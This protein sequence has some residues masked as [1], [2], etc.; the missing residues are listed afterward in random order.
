VEGFDWFGDDDLLK[1]NFGGKIVDVKRSVFTKPKFG[2]NLF[3]RLFEKGWDAFHVRDKNGRIYVDLKEDWMRPLIDSMKYNET[4][5]APISP[6]DCYLRR[7][8]SI[9]SESSEF[10]FPI[11]NISIIGPV[12]LDNGVNAFPLLLLACNL[13]NSYWN[14][15]SHLQPQEVHSTAFIPLISVEQLLRQNQWT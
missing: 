1:L 4:G 13:R 9:F 8:V 2:W 10:T 14:T 3:S 15:Y 12:V 5:K 11:L 7:S 6:C